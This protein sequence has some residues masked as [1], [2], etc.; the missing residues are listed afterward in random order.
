MAQDN[1]RLSVLGNHI[2]HRERLPRPGRAQQRLMR[3]ST[4]EP[5][6]QLLNSLRLIPRRLELGNYFERLLRLE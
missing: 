5:F 2:G 1:R 3:V 4:L 6:K